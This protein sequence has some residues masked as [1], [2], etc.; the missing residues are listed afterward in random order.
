MSLEIEANKQY[1]DSLKQLQRSAYKALTNVEAVL[2]EGMTEKDVAGLLVDQLAALHIKRYR[3]RPV[4]LFD[5]RSMFMELEVPFYYGATNKKL[6]RDVP[7]V[8]DI[9]PSSGN[10]WVSTAYSCWYG[11]ESL[12]HKAIR[13]K[14]K[15]SRVHILQWVREGKSFYDI[16]QDLEPFFEEERVKTC[17]SQYP[18]GY[19]AKKLVSFNSG[20]DGK[21]TLPSLCGSE[22]K[23]LYGSLVDWV[24]QSTSSLMQNDSAN[25]RARPSPGV[26]IVEPHAGYAGIGVKWKELLVITEHDAYWLDQDVPHWSLVDHSE[27]PSLRSAF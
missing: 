16:A 5:A 20:V 3:Y 14:L 26:W 2:Q 22:N 19:L 21:L 23:S 7:V 12:I 1:L 27:Y 24:K 17:H 8:M 9:A 6:E 13:T 18:S 10:R 4:V 25:Y 15:I 11:S